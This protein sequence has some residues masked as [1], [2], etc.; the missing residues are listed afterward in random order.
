MYNK[1]YGFSE[2]PFNVTPDPKFLFMTE[3]HEEAL[4]SM[5]YGIK[6]RQG[7][8][9]VSGEV[10]TG[11][12]TLIKHLITRLDK[13]VK[14]VFIFQTQDTFTELLKQILRE[15]GLPLEDKDKGSMTHELNKY[16][17]QRVS[18]NENL[19]LIIDEAQGLSIGVLEELRLL[20][21]LETSTSKLL[22]I[23]LVG[24]PELE[25]KL[26]SN[27]LRQLKQRIVA[28]RRIEPLS[29]E[30]SQKYIEHRLRIAGSS[31]S[32]V[33]TREAL[34]LICRHAE[35]IPR[36][37]NVI[38][39]GALLLGYGLRKEKIDASIVN[40]AI[41]DLGMAT[42]EAGPVAI[43]GEP[44]E[45]AVPPEPAVAAG[46]VAS[47]GA[48]APRDLRGQWTA[49]GKE[50]LVSRV[51]KSMPGKIFYAVPAAIFLLLLIF[52]GREYFDPPAPKTDAAQRQEPA[53]RKI[54][55]NPSPEVK[56][57]PS[58]EALRAPLREEKPTPV[59]QARQP[60]AGEKPA[61]AQ[62]SSSV[63]ESAKPRASALSSSPQVPPRARNQV[64]EVV[65]TERGTTIFSLCRKYYNRVNI[66]LMDR[67]LE[68]NPK[69]S[70]PH[71]IKIGQK[72]KIPEITG[73]SLLIKSSEGNY[74]IR[75]GTYSR[76][77]EAR[78]YQEDPLLQGKEIKVTSRK[79]S[80]Q[81]TWYRVTAGGFANRE[82]GL[83]TIQAL[84][85]KSKLP[86]FGKTS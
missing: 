85:E 55:L 73:E 57:D 30:D 69:I 46:P 74:E 49:E 17:I 28:R 41:R 64:K 33:F 60:V 19:V 6:E 40:E 15:L 58:P 43:G 79:I 78:P 56:T 23:I 47:A 44:A 34:S 11:K 9:S 18:R 52:L 10:G 1:Q 21:N 68:Y 26:N 76:P 20:S 51:R 53:V 3:S 75:L 8:I 13:K 4:A 54:P 39:E 2:K 42:G 72:I 62:V 66:S 32:K 48:F 50:P 38:C 27:E 16:L 25:D 5:I 81:E 70:A 84:K 86:F 36:K 67:I 7:F 63:S 29:E 82:E 35:G 77:E 37:I 59:A 71:L 83:K 22:Q 12:T 80:S 65:V 14:I 61:V 31:A 45:A 24:Q